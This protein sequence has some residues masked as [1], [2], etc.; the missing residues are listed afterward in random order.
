MTCWLQYAPVQLVHILRLILALFRNQSL[1]LD[2]YVSEISW[3][4]KV[5]F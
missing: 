2:P 3:E 5:T 1:F 4:E